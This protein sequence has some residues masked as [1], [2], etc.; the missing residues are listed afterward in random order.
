MMFSAIST[1]LSI[2]T[3]I[4]TTLASPI[5]ISLAPKKLLPR[6]P[7]RPTLNGSP[8]PLGAGTYPRAT[9]LR[10]G[11][12]LGVYTAFQSGSNVLLTVRS[13]NNGASWSPVGE[14]TRGP[15]DANDIDNAYLIQLPS[16][17]TRI[18][19]AFRNHSKEP[20]T[21][22]YTY[23]RIT[24]TYSDDGGKT[25]SYLSQP[26]GDNGP[27]T[28]NW[29]P[30]LRN[31]VDG[32]LQIYYSHENSAQD[33]DTLQRISRDGGA[34]WSS[35]VCVSGAGITARD[36]MTSIASI[37][38]N[39]KSLI[40]VYET[41]T[42]GL[43]SL[44]AVFSSDDGRTW[45]GRRTIFTPSSP[46]TS[47][48]APQVINAGGTLVVSFMTNEDQVLSAPANAYTDHTAVKVIT[49]GD[50][51]RGWGNKVLVG[52]AQSSWPGLLDLGSGGRFLY[53]MDRAGAKSQLVTLT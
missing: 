43:F 14:I 40:L 39:G 15:S 26:A 5:D 7:T 44:G 2:A 53:L 17:S 28:G 48:G 18:L 30:Y 19:C 1:W 21:R 51:G 52:A 16:P 4:I 46:N 3:W 29:E 13:T 10:D 38:N 12:I 35:A 45:F 50:L 11:S 8:V 20:S 47:A 9:R 33:Q 34:S 37:G 49:S 6:V 23:F 25:W 36:G 32:S 31:A 27:V 42:V 22:A 41:S 24:I